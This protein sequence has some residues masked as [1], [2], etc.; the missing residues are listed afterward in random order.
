[1]LRSTPSAVVY[2]TAC[3]IVG[4]ASDG[5]E[6]ARCSDGSRVVGS[7]CHLAP[8][9]TYYGDAGGPPDEAADNVLDAADGATGE[10]SSIVHDEEDVI[11]DDL[12][13]ET[14]RY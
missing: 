10:G 2:I 8:D 7:E 14:A 11:V 4:C 6:T 12:D 3:F 1:M 13:P 9:G 5:V